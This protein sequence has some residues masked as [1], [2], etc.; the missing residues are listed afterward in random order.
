MYF[1]VPDVVTGDERLGRVVDDPLERRGVA[2]VELVELRLELGGDPREVGGVGRGGAGCRVAGLGLGLGDGVGAVRAS[3]TAL[4][5]VGDA[6]LATVGVALGDGDGEAV[7]LGD[8]LGS[9]T[10]HAGRDRE[11]R[12]ELQ[13]RGLADRVPDLLRGD[14]G[15]ADDDVA[16][17]L[18]GDLGAGH[19]AGVDALDDDVAR[20]VQLLGGDGLAGVGARLEDD[21]GAALEVEAELGGLLR[22]GPVDGTGEEADER[23]EEDEEAREGP[24]GVGPLA[25]RLPCQTTSDAR[26]PTA[27]RS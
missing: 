11:H 1:A 8:A 27:R 10:R 17:A 21:L 25:D 18:G 4:L 26:M 15:D 20:L 3:G 6:L 13:L 24:A 5:L 9:G 16:V 7:P 12:A 14:L 22:V 23:D 19:T 2:A